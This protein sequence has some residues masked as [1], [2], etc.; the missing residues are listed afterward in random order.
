MFSTHISRLDKIFQYA[1]PKGRYH[2]PRLIRANR[3]EVEVIVAGRGY[4]IDDGRSVD[5]GPGGMVWYYPGDVVEVTS[6]ES[7]PYNTIVFEFTADG[8]PECRRPMASCWTNAVECASFCRQMLERFVTRSYPP[9]HIAWY[10]YSRL[11]WESLHSTAASEHSL[12]SALTTALR[13]IEERYLQE[14]DVKWLASSVGIS[15]PYLHQLFRRELGCPPNQ[16]IL[17]KRLERAKLLLRSTELPVKQIAVESGFRD[18]NG[19]CRTFRLK[20]GTTPA[21]FRAMA[22]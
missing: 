2:A 21:K 17:Q 1:S 4:F 10:V 11:F 7:E 18:V 22:P 3:E 16:F 12:P 15:I 6:H 20:T 9:E 8:E 19:F 5:V 13:I 14:M